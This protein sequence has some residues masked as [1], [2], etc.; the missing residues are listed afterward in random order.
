MAY[1]V[2]EIKK[3]LTGVTGKSPALV[4]IEISW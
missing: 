3:K 2:C 4:Q 1:L